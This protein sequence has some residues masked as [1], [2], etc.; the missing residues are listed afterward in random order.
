VIDGTALAPDPAAPAGPRLVAAAEQATAAQEPSAPEE[1][2]FPDPAPAE[3]PPAV[4]AKRK[5][6]P[7]TAPPPPPRRASGSKI[8]KQTA[9]ASPRLGAAAV[10][11]PASPR[12][13]AGG[14]A[15]VQEPAAQTSSPTPPPVGDITGPSASSDVSPPKR[16]EPSTASAGDGPAP[17]VEPAPTKQEPAAVGVPAPRARAAKKTMMGVAAPFVAPPLASPGSLPAAPA[18]QQVVV[19]ARR[20]FEAEAEPPPAA[21]VARKRAHK[22]TIMGGLQAP[23]FSEP[24]AAPAPA[25]AAPAE[26]HWT[27][28]LTDVDHRDMTT[29]EIVALYAIGKVTSETLVW[30]EGMPQWAR[31]FD[32]DEVGKALRA[33]GHVP[34][35]PAAAAARAR[36]ALAADDEE[37]EITRMVASPLDSLSAG[38]APAPGWREPGR[39]SDEEDEVTRAVDTDAMLLG[40]SRPT[41]DT[42]DD[43]ITRAID[44]LALSPGFGDSSFDAAPKASAVPLPWPEPPKGIDAHNEP[45]PLPRIGQSSSRTA[46]TLRGATARS[47][48]TNPIPEPAPQIGGEDEDEDE[49]SSGLRWMIAVIVVLLMAVGGVFGIFYT[50]QP[51][52]AYQKL[53]TVVPTRV[54]AYIE[55]AAIALGKRPTHATPQPAPTAPTPRPSAVAPKAA[56]PA[57][58]QLTAGRVMAE[59]AS[60]AQACQRPGGPTGLGHVLVTFDRSGRATK[61]QVLDSFANT[62]SGRCIEQLFLKAEVPPFAEPPVTVQKSFSVQ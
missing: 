1:R 23:A 55:R 2:M 17:G 25:P 21:A 57:F 39:A 52:P 30:R 13:G 24:P 47:A 51:A 58:D 33:R 14:A 5:A 40:K 7:K 12:R 19:S 20:G 61:V 8:A 49:E 3:T 26:T 31:P 44:P 46:P 6:S 22:Q 28:A 38:G 62:E 60:N 53:C 4:A 9:P 37:D 29:S 36:P 15:A 54:Q 59:T 16:V 35:E 18:R 10:Q 43:E 41:G 45:A 11:K 34:P 48:P 27:V 32:V 56:G 42:D 50:E